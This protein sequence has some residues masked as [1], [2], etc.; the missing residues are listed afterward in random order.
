MPAVFLLSIFR[1]Q[2]LYRTCLVVLLSLILHQ[3]LLWSTPLAKSS[4]NLKTVVIDPGHGGRDTGCISPWKTKEK[5]VTLAI[6]LKL[7][8][9]LKKSKYEVHLT[10]TTDDYVSLHQRVQIANSYPPDKTLF[11]SIHCNAHANRQIF[12]MESYIFDLQP[13]DEQAAKL[14]E[15]ENAEEKMDLIHFIESSLHKRGSERFSWDAAKITQSVLVTELN[16]KDRNVNAPDGSV[17]RA[18]FRVLADTK[19]PAILIEL[20]FLSNLTEHNQLISDKRQKKIAKS[21]V[22]AIKKFDQKTHPET[23]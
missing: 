4:Y 21:I 12:G 19:M 2:T 14:A 6:S 3:S 15:R 9:E 8:K 20:G 17:K 10:R 7:A 13:S 23:K 11:I 22:N 16:A 1:Y 18:P 5:T